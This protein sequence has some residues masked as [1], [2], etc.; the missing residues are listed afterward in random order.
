M[1][2][3]PN[4]WTRPTLSSCFFPV[5]L[6]MYHLTLPFPSSIFSSF[7]V[8]CVCARVFFCQAGFQSIALAG[9][10][11]KILYP[12]LVCWNCRHSYH[13]YH[14]LSLHIISLSSSTLSTFFYFICYLFYL[15]A[16]YIAFLLVL[17]HSFF[18]CFLDDLC[19]I[20]IAMFTYIYIYISVW[21]YQWFLYCFL[22]FA[23][24]NL[25]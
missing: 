3:D 19:L 9:L 22:T 15:F 21:G 24:E 10:E 18:F 11:L 6:V 13:T 7:L 5:S 1:G 16:F 8:L 17:H 14:C 20:L 12:C 2:S 4:S 23:K 25:K